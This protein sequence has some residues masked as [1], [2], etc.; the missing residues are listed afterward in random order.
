MNIL[1]ATDKFK[2]ALSAEE[3]NRI[4]TQSINRTIPRAKVTAL[5]LSD[6]GDG[7]LKMITNAKPNLI[8]QQVSV[9]DPLG[10]SITAAYLIDK[11]NRTAF[12]ELAAASGLELLE[13]TE[14]NVLNTHTYGT[15]QLIRHALEQGVK[16]CVIGLGGSATNDAGTGMA[17]ALG[18]RFLNDRGEELFPRG[19]NLSEIT[20][21]VSPAFP[22]P[23]L[24]MI[25]VND[26]DNPLCGPDGAVMTYARQKG[27]QPEDLSR[28]EA[29]MLHLEE[30][31]RRELGIDTAS[32]PGSGAAG[33]TAW[34]LKAFLNAE[35]VSGSRFMLQLNGI[36]EL[37]ESGNIQL[38]VTGEG[39]MDAQTMQ[40][41]LV[42]GI[43]QLCLQY[44]VPLVA[45]C[46]VNQLAEAQWKGL[47]VTHLVQISHPGNSLEENI[48]R[49]PQLLADHAAQFFKTLPL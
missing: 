39:S 41:K 13:T 44:K 17:R 1:L 2:G 42:Y 28:L 11:N 8:R 27:A 33:G 35:Y 47:G 18:Y 7:F 29:G 16:K 30:V 22:I 20:T 23:D 12:F 34:G 24:E 49:A 4:L 21:I 10:R 31:V 14:R 5:Q 6:G 9:Q 43:G 32:E 46:G 3:I 19:G 40:G 45:F 37:L 48:R 36:S 26:V 38:V 25:A 15:G